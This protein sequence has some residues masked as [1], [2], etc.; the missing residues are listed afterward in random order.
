MTGQTDMLLALSSGGLSWR[1]LNDNHRDETGHWNEHVWPQ[2]MKKSRNVNGKCI[3]AEKTI[4]DWLI[5]EK[6]C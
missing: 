1:N 2:R 3:D 5:P 4:L 6:L